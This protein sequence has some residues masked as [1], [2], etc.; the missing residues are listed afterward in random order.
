MN[1]LKQQQQWRRSNK[2]DLHQFVALFSFSFFPTSCFFRSIN[3]IPESRKIPQ[4]NKYNV[5]LF[6]T[7]CVN[8]WIFAR[9]VVQGVYVCVCLGSNFFV[10][11]YC[12]SFTA[13]QQHVLRLLAFWVVTVLPHSRSEAIFWRR[14]C[15]YCSRFQSDLFASASASV[16]CN[17][18]LAPSLFI[19]FR[20]YFIL[21]SCCCCVCVC[22]WVSL[23]IFSELQQTR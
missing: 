4:Y 23:F 14:R 20:K 2:N 12:F 21:V 10:A 6:T 19:K 18:L 5:C 7:T 13:C 1:I 16:I 11:I 22:V 15:C 9:F 3:K 17:V 8:L